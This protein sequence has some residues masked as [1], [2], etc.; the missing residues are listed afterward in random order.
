MPLRHSERHGGFGG[1]G[2]LELPLYGIR[3]R[4]SA[5][6]L[7]SSGPV[8][9]QVEGDTQPHPSVVGGEEAQINSYPWMAALGSRT[10]D[11][12]MVWFCGGSYIGQDLILTAAH[13]VPRPG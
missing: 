2:C 13:R 12:S 10:D 7:T 4:E 6:P 11:G 1:F 9:S 5:F 8:W 3:E